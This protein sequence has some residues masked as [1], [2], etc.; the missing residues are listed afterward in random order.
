MDN[1]QG[2]DNPRQMVWFE[3]A[4]TR[5]LNTA[6]KLRRQ[7]SAIQELDVHDIEAKAHLLAKSEEAMELVKLGA[8]LLI[9][10]SLSDT[11]RRELLEGT[12]HVR[13][14][15]LV[16]VFEDGRRE[17]FTEAHREKFRQ[18]FKAMRE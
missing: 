6:L 16:G 17:K 15:V 3:P 2:P 1:I 14:A 4:I 12:I 13:Y 9:S 11:K 10:T 7:I 8:D 18:D 5:A